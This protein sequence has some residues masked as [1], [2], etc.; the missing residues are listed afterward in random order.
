MLKSHPKILAKSIPFNMEADSINCCILGE[1]VA[2]D[3]PEFDLFIKEVVREM[4]TE[5]GQKCTAIR[6]VLVPASK[7]EPVKTALSARLAKTVVGDPAVEGV[8]M[9][10][11]ISQ[12]QREDVRANVARL[13]EQAE[14]V[15]GGEENLKVEGADAEKGA[16]YPPT[17]LYLSLIHI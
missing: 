6:R 11:L 3:D 4:T 9:G 5:A 14:L 10:P 2:E 16:F 7:V 13:M 15:I 8:R 12:S 1:S 17:V